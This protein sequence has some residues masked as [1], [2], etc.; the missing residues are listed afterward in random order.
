[1]IVKLTFSKDVEEDVKKFCKK[2]KVK[3]KVFDCTSGKLFE[4][5]LKIVKK[6]CYGRGTA[7]NPCIDCRLFGLKQAK[8]F[9]DEKKIKF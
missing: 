5:Y 3:L 1:M 4:G 7:M 9:A 8:K 6:P 2:H